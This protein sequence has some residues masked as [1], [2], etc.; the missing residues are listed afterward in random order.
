MT[1]DVECSVKGNTSVLQI[2]DTGVVG[3]GTHEVQ[4][5]FQPDIDPRYIMDPSFK[6]QFNNSVTRTATLEVIGITST[7][8]K[9]FQSC[10]SYFHS[11]V[12]FPLTLI[13][14]FNLLTVRVL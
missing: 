3:A 4:C 14:P 1:P 8:G 12:I 9:L 5:I 13:R 7:V 11:L 10:V 2:T 6:S